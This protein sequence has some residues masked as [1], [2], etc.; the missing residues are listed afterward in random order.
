MATTKMQTGG[1]RTAEHKLTDATF[2]MFRLVC[3]FRARP[4]G[5]SDAG[6]SV[7]L[8]GERLELTLAEYY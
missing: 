3:G 7:R 5:Y 4:S 2:F 6:Y 8:E 1:F